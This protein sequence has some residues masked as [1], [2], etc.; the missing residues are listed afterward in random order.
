MVLIT[1]LISSQINQFSHIRPSEVTLLFYLINLNTTEPGVYP[2]N[3][4]HFGEAREGE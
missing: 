3:D 1:E 2:S 4:L